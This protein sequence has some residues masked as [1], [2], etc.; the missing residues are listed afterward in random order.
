MSGVSTAF[1]DRCALFSEG[2]REILGNRGF[3]IVASASDFDDFSE[4]WKD[5]GSISLIIVCINDDYELMERN[6]VSFKKLFPEA[7]MVMLSDNY[8]I[9]QVQLAFRL[10]VSGYLLK[11]I[12]FVTLVK[13]LELVMLGESLFPADV[14]TEIGKE[15]GVDIQVEKEVIAYSPPPSNSGR[16]LSAREM[17]ILKCLIQGDSNKVIARRLAI[18]EATVKVHIKA[19]LRKIRVQNRTQ[20]AIWAVN[21]LEAP[22]PAELN[23]IVHGGDAII[24]AAT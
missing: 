11:R 2:V 10:S 9:R 15:H 13:S 6:I 23:G 5:S 3:D 19:I 12:N 24:G 18:G 20:A 1:I 8:N 16:G 17:Q 14:L 7:K 22:P 4:R 21:H